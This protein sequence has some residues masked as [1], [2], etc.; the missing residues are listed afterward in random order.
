MHGTERPAQ[1]ARDYLSKMEQVGKTVKD[2]EL[3]S[4]Y[5]GMMMPHVT[6]P[7]IEGEVTVPPVVPQS[8]AEGDF[9]TDNHRQNYIR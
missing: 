6:S 5:R 3:F 8:Q 4:R 1:D 9:Q 2:E 7:E